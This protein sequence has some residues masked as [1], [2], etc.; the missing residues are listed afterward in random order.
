MNLL[1]GYFL[2]GVP[3]FVFDCL[4]LYLQSFC[5][6]TVQF[7]QLF[8]RLFRCNLE[9]RQLV[10]QQLLSLFVACLYLLLEQ[11]VECL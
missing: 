5:V 8:T 2:F 4:H 6:L 3:D 10:Q 11:P 9:L 7:P 1:V